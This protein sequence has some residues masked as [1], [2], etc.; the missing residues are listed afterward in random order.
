[1]SKHPRPGLLGY[2]SDNPIIRAQRHRQ[3]AAYVIKDILTSAGRK[4]TINAGSVRVRDGMIFFDTRVRRALSKAIYG[5]AFPRFRR[6]TF[7]HYTGIEALKGIADSGEL[8][9]YSLRK[10]MQNTFEGELFN[11]A[12][13]EGWNGLELSNDDPANPQPPGSNLFHTSLTNNGILWSFGP[14]RLRLR[15]NT[16]GKLAQLREMQYHAAGDV[17]MLGK[18]NAALGAEKL[19]PILRSPRNFRCDLESHCRWH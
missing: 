16:I 14:V 15:V 18:I 7:L 11:L 10:R 1:M 5:R 6:G 9:L 17:T 8:R 13:I 12:R 19:P 2:P 3:L 4:I